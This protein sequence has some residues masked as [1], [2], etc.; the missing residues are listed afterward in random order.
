L[1]AQKDNEIVGM[2]D[3]ETEIVEIMG[4]I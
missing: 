4:S 1:Q 3:L 2:V